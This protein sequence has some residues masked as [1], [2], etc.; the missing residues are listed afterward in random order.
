M[1]DIYL[2]NTS[3]EVKGLVLKINE[4]DK[5]NK[6]K[7]INY[8]F[9]LWDRNQINSLNEIN[10]NLLD[11]SIDIEIFNP[12]SIDNPYL[13]NEIKEYWNYN[14]NLYRL[15]PKEYKELIPVFERLSFKEKKDVLAELFLILEHDK[16][17][18]DS[19]DGFEIARRILKY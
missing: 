3:N 6:L 19:I 10:P 7:F 1:F 15:Y 16:L 13:V 11:D 4:L 5:E 12:S 14:Y 8:I 17:L 9:N 18:P 2:K